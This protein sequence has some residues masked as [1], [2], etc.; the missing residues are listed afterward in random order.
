MYKEAWEFHKRAL[1]VMFILSLILFGLNEFTNGGIY[2]RHEV[3]A[4]F[5]DDTLVS[6]DQDVRPV[7]AKRCA[8][9]HNS[10]SQL[11]NILDY[12]VAYPL[13]TTIRTKVSDERSMPHYG[14]MKE[15]ERDLVK[16]WVDTGAKK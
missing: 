1:P 11:P 9:C 8:E 15:S 12:K 4:Q 2:P 16:T 14:Y 6:F 3:H 13:R 7:F 5:L 10:K